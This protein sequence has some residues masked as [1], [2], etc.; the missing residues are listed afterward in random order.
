MPR[1]QDIINK[2]LVA[3]INEIR[4]LT[5]IP[6]NQRSV[7]EWLAEQDNEVRSWIDDPVT[8]EHNKRRR[9]LVL[10]V[11]FRSKLDDETKL[12]LEKLEDKAKN[13]EEDWRKLYE[14]ILSNVTYYNPR[15]NL[16][17]ERITARDLPELV[18]NINELEK[19]ILNESIKRSDDESDLKKKINK[20]GELLTESKEYI[21]YD[22]QKMLDSKKTKDDIFNETLC[23]FIVNCIVLYKPQKT[24]IIGWFKEYY[25]GRIEQTLRDI[26]KEYKKTEQPT[27]DNDG[28]IKYP[29]DSVPDHNQNP[30]END[31]LFDVGTP[32]PEPSPQEI[33]E[34]YRI[35]F[36]DFVSSHPRATRH[37]RNNPKYPHIE[38]I[39]SQKLLDIWLEKLMKFPTIKK[40]IETAVERHHIPKDVLQNSKNPLYELW[41]NHCQV[42]LKDFE[43]QVIK[44]WWEEIVAQGGIIYKNL[45][46]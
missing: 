2:D 12:L 20:I 41:N 19:S 15:D 38:D 26:S 27:K 46:K 29:T 8:Y 28:N 13:H 37:P 34:Q 25:R 9:P 45:E 18:I 24:N 36:Q 32:T 43:E 3:C 21:K 1:E 4:Q 23:L 10:E 11:I 5:S 44:P 14:K 33:I 42:I 7:K 40:I 35:K 39:T 6:Y 17:F 16:T 30:Q 22:H 31:K